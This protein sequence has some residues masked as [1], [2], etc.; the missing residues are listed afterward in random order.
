MAQQSRRARFLENHDEPRRASVF[1]DER[2]QAAGTL[3]GSLPGM[4]F[5]H[6]GEIEGR[7]NHLPITLRVPADEPPDPASAAFFEKLL[8]ITKD[9]AFHEGQWQM[10]ETVNEG[11]SSAWN[12]IVYEWRSANSWKLIAVNLAGNA[13]QGR[14]KLGGRVD[15]AKN[16]IFNDV[17]N[18]VK[19]PRSGEELANVGLF[20]RRE[21]FSAHLFDI[22]TA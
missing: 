5:Y 10:I 19:Y 22:T 15:V 9:A 18:D 4:R 17:L 20:V 7:R 2:L 13:S 12:L 3:M 11:D 21:A 16:Y 8:Q 1:S 6:Q 14:V